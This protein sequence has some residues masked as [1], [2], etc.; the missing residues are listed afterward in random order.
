MIDTIDSAGLGFKGLTGRQIGDE[1]LNK[2]MADV[3]RQ[4]VPLNTNGKHMGT[5]SCV[6]ARVLGQSIQSLISWCTMIE[7]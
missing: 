6:M 2:E 1:Y 3:D 5:Q 4:L 7:T